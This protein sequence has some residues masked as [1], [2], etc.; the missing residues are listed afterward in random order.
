LAE[1]RRRLAVWLEPIGVSDTGIADIV[2]VVNEACTNCIEHAY[3]GIDA[4]PILVDANHDHGQI[5]V[6][7]ADHGVWQTPPTLPS[8]RGRGLPIMRAVSAGVNVNSSP[9][10]TTVRMKFDAAPQGCGSRT[11]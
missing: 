7:I 8:T 5:V 3:R 1:V 9:E 10:G 6:D 2:L 4:G 11:T